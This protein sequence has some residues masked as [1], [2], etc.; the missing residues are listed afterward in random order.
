MAQKQLQMQ[1]QQQQ[2]F[3]ELKSPNKS[4][5][6][7]PLIKIYSTNRIRYEQRIKANLMDNG[8]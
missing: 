6:R 8:H 4:T 5:N 3:E 2:Q 7:F 1:I